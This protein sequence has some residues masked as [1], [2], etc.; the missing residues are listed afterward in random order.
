MIGIMMTDA[1]IITIVISLLLL[2]PYATLY[3]AHY[4]S[5]TKL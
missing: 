5:S 4:N 3:V 2:L 1:Y